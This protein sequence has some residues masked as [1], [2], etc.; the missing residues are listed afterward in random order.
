MLL[1]DASWM[2]TLSGS[3]FEQVVRAPGNV[4]DGLQQRAPVTAVA[5]RI[6]RRKERHLSTPKPLRCLLDTASEGKHA[7]NRR[8][9]R[10]KH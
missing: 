5:F 7:P 4:L 9:N 10:I 2:S 1:P 6:R 3:A 8:M